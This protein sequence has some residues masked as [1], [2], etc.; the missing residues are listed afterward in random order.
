MVLALALSLNAC[1]DKKESTK[2]EPAESSTFASS[3]LSP[4]APDPALDWAKA[5]AAG[6]S[7]EIPAAW[8]VGPEMP[9]RAGTYF[10][11]ASDGDS[12]PAECRVNFFGAGQGGEVDD[13]ILRWARQME[14]E[15]EEG[16]SPTP[17]VRRMDVG[18]V[19][20]AVIELSGVYLSKTRP[21]AKEFTRKTGFKM[22]AAIATAAEGTV[23]FK[24]TGPLK[25]M[26]AN[27]ESFRQMIGSIVSG[28]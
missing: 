24:M 18:G 14:V 7:W 5:S 16:K 22:F 3:D 13:N 12:E 23:F 6:M 27:R 28:S 19:P 25:T 2:S 1:A 17:I 20:V 11:S 9:M 15:G 8:T 10:A 4:L 26:E 21:M